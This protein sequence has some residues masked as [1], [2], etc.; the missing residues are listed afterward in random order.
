MSG[1]VSRPGAL[2]AALFAALVLAFAGIG[3]GTAAAADAHGVD[4]G[5]SSQYNG[6]RSSA[7]YGDFAHFGHD[8]GGHGDHGDHDDHGAMATTTTTATG[9]VTPGPA[10]PERD[11]RH[12][13]VAR[14]L[15]RYAPRFQ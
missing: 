8:R 6:A 5:Y 9:E 4:A 3:A 15:R 1:I 13:R 11:P 2:A 12:V 7:H 10:L 14:R